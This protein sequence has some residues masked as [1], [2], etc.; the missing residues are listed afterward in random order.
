MIKSDGSYTYL[1]TDIAYHKNK[2]DR[3]YDIL[4]NIVGPDHHGYIP[5]IKAAVQSLGFN[6]ENL[7]FIIVQ[8]TTLYRGKEKLSMSTRKGQFISLRQLMDEVGPDEA[9]FFFIFRKAES[10]LDFDLELAKKK[11]LENMCL[12][13]R[14]KACQRS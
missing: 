13:L 4:I 11:S 1:A 8:L 12:F 9:K 6:P 2:I 10:H 5:R 7:K 3:G 14:K